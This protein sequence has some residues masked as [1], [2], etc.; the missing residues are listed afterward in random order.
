MQKAF[1]RLAFVSTVFA[2]M[3]FASGADVLSLATD[4]A[5]TTAKAEEAGVKA[6]T[7]DE[8]RVVKGGAY[9]NVSPSSYK[10]SIVRQ[11]AMIR[12]STLT[13]VK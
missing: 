10:T 5:I 4:G 9:I 2:S 11:P 8:M 3:S 12:L 13:R 6:L 7:S 1:L